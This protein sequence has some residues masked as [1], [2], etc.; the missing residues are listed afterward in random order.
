M[1]YA[2]VA[3]RP[4]GPE[5]LRRI[6]IDPPD[7]GDGEVLVRQTA[8][9]VNFIDIYIRSGSYPWPV[10]RDLTLGCEGA[11]TVQAIGPGVRGFG[12]GDRVAYTV[13]NGAYAT[14]RNVPASM[15]LR[16]PECVS[17]EQAAAS[18][19]KGLTAYYLLNDSY[20]VKD[21]DT[22]LM[23]AAAGGVGLLAGQWLSA[24]GV[25]AIGTAGGGAK[26]ALAQKN[27]YTDTVDYKTEDFVSRVRDLTGGEGV[28]AV[29]DSVGRDTVKGS[30]ECLKTFGTLVSFGQSS[31]AP[32]DFRISDLARGSLRLQR[33]TL[34]HY[35]ASRD[36][37]E[38]ASAELFAAIRDGTLKV[39]VPVRR[40]LEE[41]MQAHEDLQGRR[42]TGSTVLVP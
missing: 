26:C 21:G 16:L 5:V 39:D 7:P 8:I 31:G 3:E 25:R 24:R 18:T 1:A 36:W 11:G 22:V 29:Y 27:G 9:G 34:F 32:D 17:D 6:D 13:P 19:L 2:I 30:L 4:G 38:K 41:A 37:L 40:P 10:K 12:I 20:P 15:L 35:A 28:N 42:T 23:H 14:H 33:P